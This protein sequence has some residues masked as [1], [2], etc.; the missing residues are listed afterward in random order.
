MRQKYGVTRFFGR[1]GKMHNPKNGSRVQHGTCEDNLKWQSCFR[2]TIDER[3]RDLLE[4]HKFKKGGKN[5]KEGARLCSHIPP[6]GA[7]ERATAAASRE[8]ASGN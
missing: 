4:F 7:R 2:K 1:R 5:L 3:K 8:I 6:N